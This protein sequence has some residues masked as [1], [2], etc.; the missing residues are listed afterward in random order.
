MKLLKAVLFVEL[1]VGAA[2]TL[3]VGAVGTQDLGALT[4][5]IAAA[6]VFLVAM[7]IGAWKAI[8]EPDTRSLAVWV[9]LIPFAVL[10]LPSTLRTMF[11]DGAFTSGSGGKAWLVLAGAPLGLALVRP[12]AVGAYLPRFVVQSRAFNLAVVGLL[13]LTVGVIAVIGFAALN[14]ELVG[15]A[16]PFVAALVPIA[17]IGAIFSVFVILIAYLGFFHPEGR[18]RN[19]LRVVQLVLAIPIPLAVAAGF[20]AFALLSYD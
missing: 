15:E 10:F 9:I 3:T 16:T 19:I 7:A 12:R 20:I 11:G 18:Q 2:W 17:V 5:F 14:P 13:L 4:A 1:L 8:R 6:P